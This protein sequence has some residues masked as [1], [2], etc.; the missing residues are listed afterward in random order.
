MNIHNPD[1]MTPSYFMNAISGA[2]T[3][4]AFFR[5]DMSAAGDGERAFTVGS[6]ESFPTDLGIMARGYAA[7]VS[8]LAQPGFYSRDHGSPMQRADAAVNEVA[9]AEMVRLVFG[10][11]RTHQRQARAAAKAVAVL[12]RDRGD[13]RTP[14]AVRDALREET[15]RLMLMSPG[16]GPGVAREAVS[17]GV[18][19]NPR[20]RH[21]AEGA[22]CAMVSRPARDRLRAEDV[23]F[24]AMVLVNLVNAVRGSDIASMAV[25]S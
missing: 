14:G 17:L 7:A 25:A 21:F 15:A 6:A 16:Y 12:L 23:A 18:R 24:L 8:E 20:R 2:H 5:T 22:V 10:R 9:V 4:G 3:R 11:P 13:D 1:N 19:S